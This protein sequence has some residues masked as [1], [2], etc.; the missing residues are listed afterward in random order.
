M[1]ALKLA[2]VAAA[3][4]ASM[5]THAADI[6]LNPSF[7]QN[8]SYNYNV[9]DLDPGTTAPLCSSSNPLSGPTTYFVEFTNPGLL[10][11]SGTPSSSPINPGTSFTSFSYVIYDPS[12]NPVAT[13]TPQNPP[14][15]TV[16]A[17]VYK[18]VVTWS[19]NTSNLNSASWTITHTTSP[20]PTPE[21]G[22]LALLGLGLV[23]IGAARRR[24]A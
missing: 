6:T 15:L 9:C 10:N 14:Q 21:P 22:T 23:G 4:L 20:L 2:F 17:G 18:F 8:G 19:V 7:G 13:G 16:V 5:A 12:N 11:S 3:G 24:K 1:K